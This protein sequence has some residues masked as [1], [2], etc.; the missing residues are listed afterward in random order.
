MLQDIDSRQLKSSVAQK[1]GVPRSNI[2]TWLL[3]ANKKKIMAVFLSGKIN[4]K[5]KNMKAGKYESLDKAVFK[6]FM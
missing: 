2:S 1:Y 5:R 3:P 6:W 4:L